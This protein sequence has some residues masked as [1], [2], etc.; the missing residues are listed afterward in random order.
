MKLN[1][2]EKEQL[3]NMLTSAVF[4]K[5]VNQVLCERRHRSSGDIDK[6]AMAHSYNEG[7]IQMIESLGDLV[8]AGKSVTISPRKLR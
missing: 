1:E 4:E 6:N 3:S 2:T 8:E 7:M 5:A